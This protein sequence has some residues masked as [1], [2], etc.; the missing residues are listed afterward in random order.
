[1]LGFEENL[2]PNNYGAIDF[3]SNHSSQETKL[4]NVDTKILLLDENKIKHVRPNW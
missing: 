4:K 2:S 3:I 1:V